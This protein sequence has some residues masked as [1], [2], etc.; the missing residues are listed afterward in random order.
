MRIM[1]IS[2]S[3]TMLATLIREYFSRFG[4]SAS[5]FDITKLV[6]IYPLFFPSI[7]CEMVDSENEVE[8]DP[9]VAQRLEHTFRDDIPL[10]CSEPGTQNCNSCHAM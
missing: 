8:R 7:V 3:T 5:S 2:G 9:G 6:P 10:L 4:D 1:D